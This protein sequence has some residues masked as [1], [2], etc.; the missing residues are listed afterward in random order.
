MTNNSP[1]GKTFKQYFKEKPLKKLNFS[2]ILDKLESASEE[3]ESVINHAEELW[4]VLDADYRALTLILTELEASYSDTEITIQEA[5]RVQKLLIIEI[6]AFD[7]VM[8]DIGVTSGAFLGP[9]QKNVDVA[10]ENVNALTDLIQDLES[11]STKVKRIS[12]SY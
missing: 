6:A 9:M 8:D 10:Y 12:A 5:K 7:E 11:L 2:S 4:D 1:L 3:A